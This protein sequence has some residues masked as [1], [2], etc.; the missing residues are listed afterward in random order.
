MKLLVTKL[1]D[2][3]L[4]YLEMIKHHS[5]YE[6]YKF[7]EVNYSQVIRSN[8]PICLSTSMLVNFKRAC[9][10]FLILAML[11]GSAS[12]IFTLF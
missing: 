6:Y 5:I 12:P 3:Y 11:D 9:I 1:S 8:Q 4:N 2:N 7:I 10:I